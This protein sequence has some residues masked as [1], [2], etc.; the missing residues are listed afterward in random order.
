MILAAGKGRR[1]KNIGKKLPKCLLKIYDKSLL[2]ILV[3][4]LKEEGAKKI[5]KKQ[6]KMYKEMLYA[7]LS[8]GKRKDMN[9][10]ISEIADIMKEKGIATLS[11]D[12]GVVKLQPGGQIPTAPNVFNTK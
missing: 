11:Q 8:D 4:N 12:G 10:N 9:G 3:S 6:N 7:M 5:T 2:E 1:L